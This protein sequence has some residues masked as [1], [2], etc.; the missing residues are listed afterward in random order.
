MKNNMN[1]Y[2]LP[3]LEIDLLNWCN[4]NCAG[5][6]H[7]SPLASYELQDYPLD[8]FENDIKELSKKFRIRDIHL[9]GGEPFLLPNLLE[10]LKIIRSYFSY[11]RIF[12][13]TNGVLAEKIESLKPELTKLRIIIILSNYIGHTKLKPIPGIIVRPIKNF[14]NMGLS[15][16]PKHNPLESKMNCVISPD[17]NAISLYKGRIYHCSVMK[18]L[19][20]L[21]KAF[22]L[23]FKIP[24]EDRGVDLYQSAES[25]IT[26]LYDTSRWDKLCAHCPSKRCHFAWKLSQKDL[27]EWVE[28]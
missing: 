23:D 1:K 22:N 12:I 10:Y 18:N 16:E 25:I 2:F 5:C 6:T 3:Y 28:K 15:L 24:L 27:S 17:K 4:L 14:H 7:F 20:V 26:E 19:S 9:L 11:S 21:E 8:L 13:D